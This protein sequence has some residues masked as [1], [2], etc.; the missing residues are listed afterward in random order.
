[1]PGVRELH[2]TDKAFVACRVAL[3]EPDVDFRLK[4]GPTDRDLRH[5]VV[6]V[7]WWFIAT[8]TARIYYYDFRV[9]H[10]TFV[11]YAEGVGA[12]IGE[13]VSPA[14]VSCS[15]ITILASIEVI[16]PTV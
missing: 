16:P 5:L 8:I 15:C 2:H 14:T 12:L 7:L 13:D 1:M 3:L 6:S 4:L 11:P 10:R 9:W